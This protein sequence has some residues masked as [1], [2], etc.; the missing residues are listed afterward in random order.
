MLEMLF[1]GKKKNLGIFAF[2]LETF[3]GLLKTL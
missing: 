2:Y 1:K 3:I